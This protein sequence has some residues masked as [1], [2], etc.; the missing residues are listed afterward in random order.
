MAAAK[1]AGPSASYAGRIIGKLKPLSVFTGAVAGNPKAEVEIRVGPDGTIISSRL[2]KSSGIPAWDD[3]V[4]RAIDKAGS[5]PRDTDGR[6]PSSM[7]IAW[8]PND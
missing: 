1:T 4:Q 6:V 3:A 2:I 5:L 7:I 8:G